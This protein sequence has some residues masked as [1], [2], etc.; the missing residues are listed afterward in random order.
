[1][2]LDRIVA[3]KREEVAQLR[4][5]GIVL[6][7]AFQEGPVPPP[8]G[9]TGALIS[10]PGVAVIAEVKRASPS[11]G[12]ISAD[13]RPVA[14]AANYQ[15]QG[16]RAISVLTDHDFFQGSLADLMAV[17]AAVQLPVLRKDFLIDPLQIDQ[18]G[19]HGADAVLLIA[20][21][22]DRHQLSDFQ[23]RA[24]EL[25]MD[26][27]VEVHN[28]AE[29]ELALAAGARL[30]GINN[31]NL[32]DFSMDFSTT[33]R[34]K[35]LIPADIP[36]VSESGLRSADDFQRLRAAGVAAAL[37]GE[38]LMRAGADSPLLQTLRAAGEA[39]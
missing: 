5:Q 25:G 32:N 28:E 7:A 18:A 6:P 3:R 19:A 36:V 38:T 22:L 14:I 26:S 33:F 9:F 24:A 13:F 27:L 20:A 2:I 23:A 17:R 34:L 39:G 10:G 31:R 1:M 21:I 4:R 12:V 16:A 8:R 37:V 15:R 35:K 11:K 29:T 30:I